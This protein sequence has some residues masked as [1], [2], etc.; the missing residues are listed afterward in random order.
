MPYTMQSPRRLSPAAVLLPI[1]LCLFAVRLPTAP[2]AARETAVDISLPAGITRD[3]YPHAHAVLAREI[4]TVTFDAAGRTSSTDEVLL[5]ILDEQG[6]REHG[7]QRFSVN[8]AY[9][10]LEIDHV[11]VIKADGSRVEVNLEQHSREETS[12]R[13]AQMNIY[14]PNM[15]VISVFIPDLTV[16]DTIH[17]RIRRQR[18]KPIIPDQVYGMV[19]GQY[20]FPIHEYRFTLEGPSAVPLRHLVKDEVEGAV[21]YREQE[22]DGRIIR[23]WEFHEVPQLVPEPH[24]P[25]IS[26]VAMRLLFSSIGSWNDIARWYAGLVEPKLEP[27]PE[28]VAAVAEITAGMN[29]DAEKLAAIFHFVARRIR[30]MGV[31]TETDRPGFE[32]HAAR[33]TF[34]RRHGVCRDKA[35]L[36]VSLLRLAGFDA[37][38]VLISVGDK[39]DPEIP[40]PYFNHA[41]TVAHGTAGT[42]AV[43]APIFMDP[44]DETGGQFL[45]DYERDASY[46]VA[47]TAGDETLGLT[48]P[49]PAAANH[50][51]ITI[52]DTLER[53]GTL[54]GSIAVACRGFAGAA[55]RSLLMRR[56]RAEREDFFH[57]MLL[58]RRPGI[59]IDELRW[60]DPADPATPVTFT[61]GFSVAAAVVD[62]ATAADDRQYILP[63]AA[64]AEP[65]LLDRWILGRAD[66]NDRDFPLRFGYTYST[67]VRERLRFA[68]A[69]AEIVLPE[70]GG[71]DSDLA[72]W[73][74]S[75]SLAAADGL[76]IN[77]E[78]AL[79][80]L[81]AGPER[82]PEITAMQRQRQRDFHAPLVIR[83]H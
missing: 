43:A 15:L 62:A 73:R 33:D 36:L 56:G 41:I 54:H 77:R 69:P 76:T 8:R 28:M 65:G 12:S 3:R 29:T 67:S 46:L 78:F 55:M 32:P 82:Y 49:L 5:T 25:P 34:S 18:H 39:L 52:N 72:T 64:M 63:L 58:R 14:N 75:Y 61:C 53:D 51:A 83:Y 27:S 42:A 59:V 13:D 37:N 80:Q 22:H 71:T 16:G 48:P 31:T 7:V 68:E 30:Y 44:T 79:R 57:Q 1:L 23:T 66:M 35:A 10:S 11:A 45:P 19:L 20:L 74:T 60:S 47:G 9:G 21:S 6:K 2:A 24:M 50:F 17:Y 26:E 81:Q 70:G 38:A 4:E 40:L